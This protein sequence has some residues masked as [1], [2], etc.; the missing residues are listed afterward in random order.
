[1]HNIA[2]AIKARAAELLTPSHGANLAR[3]ASIV[4]CRDHTDL[5]WEAIAVIHDLAVAHPAHSRAAVA[6][7]RSTDPD[8]NHR[9]LQLRDYAKELQYEAG[10]ANANLTR[11]LTTHTE[12]GSTL[13][14]L[15]PTA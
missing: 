6:R 11:G 5:T 15:R 10:Y 8:F 2:T 14:G 7:H 4:V 12:H 1:M 3:G 13:R 9:Y